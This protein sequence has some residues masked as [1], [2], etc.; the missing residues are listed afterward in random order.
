M[1]K[2]NKKGTFLIGGLMIIVLLAAFSHIIV[3]KGSIIIYP[4]DSFEQMY[5]FYVGGWE[6]YHDLS[7]SQW[8]WSLGLG[9]SFFSYVYYFVTSPFF[10]LSLLLSKDFIKYTFL[11]FNLLKMFCLFLSVMFWLNKICKNWLSI[12]VGGCI[13]AFSGWVFFYYNYNCF[14]D[15]IIFY[16]IALAGAEYYLQNDKKLP[17]ILSV[18]VLGIV[19]YY[20]LYMFIPFLWMYALFRYLIIHQQ[21]LSLKMVLMDAFKFAAYSL[22]G[23]LV[24]AVVLFPCAKLITGNGRFSE[25][26]LEHLFLGKKD[27]FKIFSSLFVPVTERFNCNV[28]IDISNHNLLGWGGGTS[29]YSLMIVPVSLVLIS[30]TPN[31]FTKFAF[32]GFYGVLILMM[33]LFPFYRLFQLTIDSR[34][35]YMIIFLNALTAAYVLDYHLDYHFPKKVIRI[36]FMFELLMLAVVVVVSI[37]LGVSQHNKWFVL[38]PLLS[39]LLILIYWIWFEAGRNH[40]LLLVVV[41]CLECVY[42]GYVYNINNDPIHASFFENRELSTAAISLIEE[43]D[44][45]EGFYR[46]LYGSNKEGFDVWEGNYDLF[47]ANEPFAKNFAGVSFY[48][49]IYSSGAEGFLKRYKS[50]WL[51]PQ[52]KGRIESY[53]LV[54]AK[55]W[56]ANY[57]EIKPPFGYEL[58]MERDGVFIYENQ[59]YINLGFAYE[60]TVNEAEILKKD[61]L[62]QDMIM[63]NYLVTNES[64]NSLDDLGFESDLI[65]FDIMDTNSVQEIVFDSYIEDQTFYFLNYGLDNFV[66]RLYSDDKLVMSEKY[67][68]FNYVD[69]QITSEMKVNRIEFECYDTYGYGNNIYVYHRP[70]ENYELWYQDISERMFENVVVHKDII[71]ADITVS[72]EAPHIFT[73]IPDDEGW[74]VYVDDKQI[75]TYTCHLGL[76]GFDLAKG[77]HHVKFVYRTPYLMSGIICSIATLILSF[78]LCWKKE[79]KTI[80][81]K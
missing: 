28:L 29:I 7:V 37:L 73:S 2:L 51:M 16:P 39:G 69:V 5:Q 30:F 15:A 44:D 25:V 23:V 45:T 64:K 6:K 1:G 18:G 57:K 79:L 49:T 78:C 72:A 77:T 76:I 68:Q 4:G 21:S 19:N 38:L 46:I 35:F 42:C 27:L 9:G 34:W 3:N 54:G 33:S 80:V 10:L 55:Y 24:S 61:Y 58:V 71:E 50:N 52:V 14:L 53:N 47:T 32:C 63:L 13:V 66:L 75:E 70:I 26:T 36:S 81:R 56:Y 17:L 74:S 65:R 62:Q 48:S 41:V 22:L 43:I 40:Q 59:Y 12:F 11:Y 67:V 31:R 60:Q 20:F 8:D